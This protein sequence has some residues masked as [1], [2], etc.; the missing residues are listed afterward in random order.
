[1]KKFFTGGTVPWRDRGEKGVVHGRN[2]NNGGK[3]HQG[4]LNK[5]DRKGQKG[6]KVGL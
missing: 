2:N 5:G 4:C 3:A 1:M 6:P